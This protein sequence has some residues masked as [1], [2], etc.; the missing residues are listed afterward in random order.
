VIGGYCLHFEAIVQ[1]TMNY[2]IEPMAE[3]DWPQVRQIHREGIATGNATFE[4]EPP[5]WDR[6][7]SAHRKDS[8]LV[9]R[10]GERVLGWAA[11]SPVSEQSVYAGVAEVSVYVAEIARGRLGVR[12][13]PGK[14]GNIWRD[15]V[16]LERRSQ[17]SSV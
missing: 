4:T 10:N 5:D 13:W 8:R 7:T 1:V 16:L 11:L 14:M 17:I 3:L 12:E 2:L 9:A 6:W 15:V